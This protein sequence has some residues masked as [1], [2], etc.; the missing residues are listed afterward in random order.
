ML[1]KDN[2]FKNY[3]VNSSRYYNNIKKTKK[4]YHSFLED[5]KNSKMHYTDNQLCYLNSH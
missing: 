4:I 1:K 2:F 5:I 3:S